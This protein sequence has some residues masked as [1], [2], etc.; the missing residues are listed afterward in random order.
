MPTALL[1]L[2]FLLLLFVASCGAPPDAKK[3]GYHLF[4]LAGQSNMAG[5]GVVSDQDR[6]VN[7]EVLVLSK[8][9]QWVPAVDPI[10][11]DKPIAGVGPGRSFALSVL[12]KNPGVTVGLI[13]AA[14]GGS[15][16]ASW[17]PGVMDPATGTH[18]YDDALNRIQA[19]VPYGTLKAVLWHQGESDSN[20]QSAP[21]YKEK[22]IAL[23]NRFREETG[24]PEL[25]FIIGQLGQF[26]EAPWNDWREMVNQ[27]HM[28]VAEAMPHVL[29]VRSDDLS[30]KGDTLHFSA[31]A[32]RS[33]GQRLAEAYD[34]VAR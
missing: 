15:P 29:F 12:E 8:E 21:V 34:E 3:E 1:R 26:P 28:E 11:Y 22:L 4:L 10:H 33:L 18:P 9:M 5:R 25:L 20:E 2:A 17:E 16:I 27:A 30:H 7:P 6:Q 32:A 19:A 13:P 31:A 14:V 24:D 23:I